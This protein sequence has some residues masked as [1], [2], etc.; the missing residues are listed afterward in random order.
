MSDSPTD[1]P[2]AELAAVVDETR[3][4]LE[5]MR[6]VG[7]RM[8]RRESGASAATTAPAA[9]ALPSVSPQPAGPPSSG[10]SRPVFMHDPA[11]PAK[12][13]PPPASA[14]PPP[15]VKVAAPYSP[16]AVKAEPVVK[17]AASGLF[18]PA[19][20]ATEGL[21]EATAP[22]KATALKLIRQDLGSCTRCQL[23]KTR[24]TIVYGQGNPDAELLFLG[25]APGEDEDRSGLAFVGKAGQLLTRMIEAMGYT[26]DDVYICNINKCRPPGNRKPEP[27]EVAA[28]RPIVERQIL[29][30][31]PKVIV[32][33][34]A[35]ATQT[36]LNT[37][38]GITKLRNQWTEWQGIPVMP[39]FHPSYLLR[40]PTEK[41][42]AWD[43]LKLVLA[44]VGKQLPPR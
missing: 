12:P 44:K 16:P 25:E 2:R 38:V 10:R 24:T 11:P 17:P 4:H 36:L 20:I 18:A 6:D 5:W 7:V 22:D 34:G 39:T 42:K 21:P 1:D 40:V 19:R 15:V 28:C 13:T 23:S 30:I 35:T 43:D 37:T 9:P 33:L 8:L 32:A 27:E 31:R 14:P 26:R 41:G 3:R 29:A